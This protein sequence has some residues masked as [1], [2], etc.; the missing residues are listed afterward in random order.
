MCL[1]SQWSLQW[2]KQYKINQVRMF[3]FLFNQMIIHTTWGGGVMFLPLNTHSNKSRTDT[4]A[5]SRSQI[6]DSHVMVCSSNFLS[7]EISHWYSIEFGPHT[8]K[9]IYDK[10]KAICWECVNVGEVMTRDYFIWLKNIVYLDQKH[11]RMSWHLH[12]N[13][14]IL[15]WFWV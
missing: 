7:F 14:T 2:P 5:W 15:I 11:K 1:S 4:W 8:A 12:K 3:G 13:M 10:H 6:I 9:K